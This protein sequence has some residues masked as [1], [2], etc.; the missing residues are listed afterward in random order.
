MDILAKFEAIEIKADTRI[1]EA[2]RA[3]C[4]AHQAAYDDAKVSLAELKFL[5]KDMLNH[6]KEILSKADSAAPDLYIFS[7]SHLHITETMIQEQ[8]NALHASFIKQ[9]V[10]YFNKTY[11]CC[12]DSDS[13]VCNLLPEE[14]SS[15]EKDYAENRKRYDEALLNLSLHYTDILEQI[16]LQTEGRELHEQAFCQLAERC[17]QAAWS[18]STKEASFEQKKN[19]IQFTGYFCSYRNWYSQDSWELSHSMRNIL[20]GIAHFETQSL[21]LIPTGISRLLSSNHLESSQYQFASCQKIQS[22]K[23]FK[24]G[25]VDIKFTTEA[26]ACQFVETYL[27]KTY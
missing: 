24:N 8:I 25:R 12:L 10:A 16:F 27:G 7:Y 4:Q 20:S 19:G 23:L 11:H 6:Q 1:S 15:Y 3:V 5:W 17:H 14:P 13:M 26:Y 9:L 18:Y 22:L 21:S 2:D